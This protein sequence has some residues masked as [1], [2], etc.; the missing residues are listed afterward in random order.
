MASSN[1]FVINITKA[2]D[3]L[4]KDFH[5]TEDE[6]QIMKILTHPMADGA[7]C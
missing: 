5:L 4:K 7:N 1:A 6:P 3:I 2:K